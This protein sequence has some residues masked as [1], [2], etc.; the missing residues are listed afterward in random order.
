MSQVHLIEM[1]ARVTL[2]EIRELQ[3]SLQD[4][5]D[6]SSALKK[7]VFDFGKT[8]LIDSSG[9]VYLQQFCRQA[10]KAGI[11][12]MGWSLSPKLESLIAG[13]GLLKFL[14]IDPAMNSFVLQGGLP[15]DSSLHPA[16]TSKAKRF[17][18]V[19]G[20]VVGLGITSVLFIPVAIA[21]KLESPGPILFSQTRC[22][23]RGQTF[24]IWKFRSMVADAP[25]LKHLVK[26]HSQG[27]FFKNEN[28]P[29]ITKVGRFLRRTSLDELPQF[30][31]ILQGEMSLV[32]T[33][34]PTLDE[35][36]KYTAEQGQ[37][38]EVKPG[39]TGE[40]QVNGRSRITEFEQ[41]V[42]LD[43]QYQKNWS[44]WHD[45]KLVIK[46]IKYLFSSKSGAC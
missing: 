32:G 33:R 40:W 5:V 28:D 37:R 36:E 16:V 12:L 11:E 34:P 18:D 24:R 13:S 45:I 46:T 8:H 25:Q 21:I 7:I 6:T 44:V 4:L 38:L 14:N 1:P 22:G 30:W 41:V 35:V 39:L 27:A 20:A 17:L 2:L 26:N 15:V 3:A 42:K 43:L 10:K 29:R 9:I 31:N 19:V 23:H